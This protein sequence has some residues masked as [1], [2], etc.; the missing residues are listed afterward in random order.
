MIITTRTVIANNTQD[1]IMAAI[2]Y[3]HRHHLL[4]SFSLLT[5]IILVPHSSAWV[6]QWCAAGT[7]GYT[8]QLGKLPLH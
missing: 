1:N 6:M 2:I 7:E 3:T 5:D 8:P 4:L